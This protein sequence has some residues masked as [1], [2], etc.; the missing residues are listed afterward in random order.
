MTYTLVPSELPDTETYVY[1]SSYIQV[2][3]VDETTNTS[4]LVSVSNVVNVS[5]SVAQPNVTVNVSNNKIW[6]NGYYTTG[7]SED[8]KYVEP[9]YGNDITDTPTIV[10]NINSV[11]QRKYIYHIS[12]PNPTGVTVTQSFTVNYTSGGNTNFTIDRYVYPGLYQIYNF[13]STYEWYT[14][15]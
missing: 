12:Q 6:V 8:I 14:E 2:F 10:Y 11:P 1:V 5:F 4:N 13:L 7:Q 15:E 9:P 3:D